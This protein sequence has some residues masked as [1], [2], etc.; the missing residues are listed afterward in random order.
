MSLLVWIVFIGIAGALII[1]AMVE[2]EQSANA[3]DDVYQKLC[4]PTA[5]KKWKKNMAQLLLL[6][7]HRSY[8]RPRTDK[9]IAEMF[10]REWARNYSDYYQER[11]RE[12]WARGGVRLAP[13]TIPTTEEGEKMGAQDIQAWWRGLKP[14]EL[15]KALE[16]DRRILVHLSSGTEYRVVDD[17]PIAAGT[18][19][20]PDQE[21]PGMKSLQRRCRGIGEWETVFY[22]NS[23]MRDSVRSVMADIVLHEYD[24]GIKPER[25]ECEVKPRASLGGRLGFRYQGSL[26]LLSNAVNFLGFVGYKY[27]GDSFNREGYVYCHTRIRGQAGGPSLAETPTHV[28]I[29]EA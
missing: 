4:S 9:Q 28:I 11:L 25:I 6:P 21:L 1:K 17:G 16:E 23:N 18:I 29:E 20:N 19:R 14:Y 5:Y 12:R 27:E 24:W 26:Y 3:K 15:I 8:D 13:C 22:Q 2:V 10:G 7:S